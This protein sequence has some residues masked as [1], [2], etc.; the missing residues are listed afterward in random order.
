M[1]TKIILLI[2]SFFLRTELFSQQNTELA[3]SKSYSFE[4]E[5]QYSKAIAV[6]LE[7]NIDTYQINLRLGWLNYLNKD[8]VKS[9][10]F[11]KKAV[12]IEPASVEARFGLVLP[13]S[14]LGNWNSVLSVYLDIIKYDPNNSTANYRIASIYFNRKE[15]G[16][17]STYVAKV[18]RLYPFDYDSNLLLGKILMAQGKNAEAKKY[19]GKALEYNPSSDEVKAEI[20]KL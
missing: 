17:A 6:L 20:K 1:K 14:A 10:T 3:F 4:Y 13:M 18:L 11:Y 9:E 7:L 19:L 12:A 8:Y 2:L 15:F 5:T 16:N